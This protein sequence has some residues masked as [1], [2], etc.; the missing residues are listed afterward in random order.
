MKIRSDIY[1]LKIDL[2]YTSAKEMF[3]DDTVTE[4]GRSLSLRNDSEEEGMHRIFLHDMQE[5]LG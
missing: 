2:A 1:F 3:K 5:M 4:M